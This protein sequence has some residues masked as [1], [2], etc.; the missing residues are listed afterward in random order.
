[1]SQWV[2]VSATNLSWQSSAVD[3]RNVGNVPRCCFQL[4]SRKME[5]LAFGYGEFMAP[6]LGLPSSQGFVDRRQKK[7]V[8]PLQV[9]CC[10]YIGFSFSKIFV[11]EM[12]KYGTGSFVFVK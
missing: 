5:S 4:G 11:V 7:G 9:L 10:V 3:F 8:L 6:G 2:S 1:M 12:T